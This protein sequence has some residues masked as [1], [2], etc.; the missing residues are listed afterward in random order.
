MWVVAY[1]GTF[2]LYSN[3]PWLGCL[4][5]G[6]TC[7][8]WTF[9][10]VRCSC[11]MGWNGYAIVTCQQTIICIHNHTIMYIYTYC[12]TLFSHFLFDRTFALVFVVHLGASMVQGATARSHG[13]SQRDPDPICNL[14]AFAS[15]FVFEQLKC[16]SDLLI[17]YRYLYPIQI[18]KSMKI[19]WCPRITGMCQDPMGSDNPMRIPWS[20]RRMRKCCGRL[21]SSHSSW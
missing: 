18:K 2:K 20:N 10:M 4:P 1:T 6:G 3:E 11:R 15:F 17:E 13:W 14:G 19:P 8:F 21:V 9:D 16:H 12:I 7:S 5:Q